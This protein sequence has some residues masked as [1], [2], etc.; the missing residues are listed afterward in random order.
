MDRLGFQVDGSGGTG[1]EAVR[2][3]GGCLF[4]WHHLVGAANLADSLGGPRSVAGIFT[5]LLQMEEPFLSLKLGTPRP[6]KAQVVRI[7]T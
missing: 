2:L 7:Q 6:C 3:R 5:P 4:F 1:R